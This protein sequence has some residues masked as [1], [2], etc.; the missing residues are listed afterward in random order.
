MAKS[1]G[2]N[3]SGCVQLQQPIERRHLGAGELHDRPSTLLAGQPIEELMREARSRWDLVV[4]DSPPT[5]LVADSLAIGQHVD[6]SLLA[7]F[8]D[9]SHIPS[10]RTAC[11]RLSSVNVPIAG[12][13]L[14]GQKASR[15]SKY[16]TYTYEGGSRAGAQASEPGDSQTEALQVRS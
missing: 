13:V 7:V 6:S 3:L 14:T 4:V 16:D 9:V 12:A 8:S 2:P 1:P 5:L 11:E 15:Y 10:V